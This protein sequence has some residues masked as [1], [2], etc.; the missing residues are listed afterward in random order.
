MTWI[1]SWLWLTQLFYNLWCVSKR[2]P[3]VGDMVFPSDRTWL[4]FYFPNQVWSYQEAEWCFIRTDMSLP[5][6][7]KLQGQLKKQIHACLM[8][9]ENKLVLQIKAAYILRGDGWIFLILQPYQ[10]SEASK[11]KGL[12]SLGLPHCFAFWTHW[13]E[14]SI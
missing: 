14:E 6:F 5:H 9:S 1:I 13:A 4:V 8:H 7:P 11:H 12:F 3:R 10:Q 2:L